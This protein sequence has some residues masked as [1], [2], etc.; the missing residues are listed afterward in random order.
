MFSASFQAVH[1]QF[2]AT[3]IIT[4][5]ADNVI[6][7]SSKVALPD[8]DYLLTDGPADRQNGTM[9]IKGSQLVSLQFGNEQPVLAISP[10]INPREVVSI[11]DLMAQHFG[12]IHADAANQVRRAR[13]SRRSRHR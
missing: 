2:M 5:P 8:G 9:A 4:I 11:A 6:L 1:G 12:D 10:D 13:P 7:L 3:I